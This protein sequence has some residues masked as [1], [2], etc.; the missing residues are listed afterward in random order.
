MER[1]EELG[2][3]AMV[4]WFLLAVS[5]DFLGAVSPGSKILYLSIGVLPCADEVLFAKIP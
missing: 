3:L 2:M 1:E 4:E 5:G